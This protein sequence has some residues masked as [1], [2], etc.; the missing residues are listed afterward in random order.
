VA[1]ISSIRIDPNFLFY[2]PG[3]ISDVKEFGIGG[4]ATLT[5][6]DAFIYNKSLNSVFQLPDSFSA[7]KGKLIYIR[8]SVGF[9]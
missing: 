8:G 4:N 7:V 2:V 3:A 6:T 1:G 5:A 9:P